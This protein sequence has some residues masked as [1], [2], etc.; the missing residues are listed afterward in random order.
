M[1]QIDI[2]PW[3]DN[4]NTGI[5]IIDTQHRQ[6]VSI[7]NRLATHI[8]Y[9]SGRDVLSTTFDELIDYTHYHFESEEAIWHQYLPNNPLET[10]HEAVHQAFIETVVH[11]KEE[12]ATRSYDTTA[13]ETLSF[14]AH[15]LATHILETDRYMAQVILA[16][17]DG[18]SL[19]DAEVRAKENVS[20][21]TGILI[22]IILSRYSDLSSNTTQLIGEIQERNKI[23]DQLRQQKILLQAILDNAPLGIWMMSSAGKMQ[24]VN[25][26]F[27]DETGISEAEFL[28]A[29][30]YS[31][32]L[33]SDI[34]A[35]CMRSDQECLTQSEDNHTS[36]ELITFTDGKKHLL[37]ITKI[38]L[39]NVSE[40]DGIIGLAVDI[41]ERQQKEEALQLA[42]SV[43]THAGEGIV[44]TDAHNN[45][46]EANNTFSL[47]TGYTREE[48]LGKN[49]KF[50]QSGKQD[51]KFYDKMWNSL[52]KDDYWSGEIWNRRKS[53]EEY[54]AM[55]TIS[56]ILDDAGKTRNYVA[57]FSDITM[58]KEHQSQLEHI[59]HYD[60]LTNLPNR[61]LLANRLSQA[62]LDNH[63]YSV[64]VAFIDIDGFKEINDNYGH[65][66]GDDLLIA[67]SKRMQNTL[68]RGDTLAR[69]GGDEFLI[70]LVDLKNIKDSEPMLDRLLSVISDPMTIEDQKISVTASVG[71]SISSPNSGMNGDQLIRQADQAMYQAKQS[72]KNCYHVFD[73]QKDSAITILR[74]SLEHIKAALD[75]QEFILYYQP[76]VNMSTGKVIGAEA[77][78]RWR[79]PKRGLVQP[80]GFLPIIEDH[81]LSIELGEWVIDT[82]L[83]QIEAWKTA[84]LTIP[85][86]VNISA[87][88]LQQ[89]NF[90][91]RLE[92]LLAKHPTVDPSL[93]EL[94]VLETSAIGDIAQVSAVMNSCL[95]LGVKFALDDFGTGYSSLTYLRRLPANLIKIDQI[96]VRD[97]L[98]DPDDLAIVEGVVG[99]AKAFGREVIA[100]GVE[101][102]EHGK[103]LLQI[104]CKLAQGYGIARPMKASRIPK[105][106]TSWK[107]DTMWSEFVSDDN[108]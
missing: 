79:H 22:N 55:L 33:P 10:E 27:C 81:T 47:I 46:V 53:G 4:F 7:L 63:L 28:D 77:L 82:A 41:T 70:I 34:A 2:F 37:E 59:A 29:D 95:D 91:S 26:T 25:K 64:A 90:V 106:I 108:D 105:W 104:G 36:R 31:K 69:I 44:I 89:T 9:G 3:D 73:V 78:I 6:L 68:R 23:S 48:V 18:L 80:I 13:Q 52:I 75:H 94:E 57:L 65:N 98:V 50:L 96:F 14:L 97:M 19:I 15:W 40:T 71:L 39:S 42:A 32:L 24:F 66:I 58:A 88:Q 12:Q 21:L 83:G 99:L 72:G 60:V 35:S 38:N 54:A 67:L 87:L 16:L 61:A 84:G 20:G 100:E 92:E 43:F 11:L 101:T 86:S 103:A 30:H 74:E 107:P 62:L 51:S 5:E 17:K 8:V 45:I 85:V 102:I 1:Q 93:L 56:A 49:P 76:K